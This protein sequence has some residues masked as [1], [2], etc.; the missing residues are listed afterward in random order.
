MRLPCLRRF[1]QEDRGGEDPVRRAL[2]AGIG[3]VLLGD[4]GIGPCVVRLLEAAYT[5]SGEVEI[6]DLGTPSLDLTQRIAGL[7]S[8]IVIDCV[9]SDAAPGTVVFYRKADIVC[10]KLPDRLDPHSPA[11]AECLM[12]AEM[13]G[14]SPQN[15]LLI[16]IVGE[17]CEPGCGLSPAVWRS[18]A[19]AMDAVLLELDRL[20]FD[21]T[22][23][24][25][26][27]EPAIWWSD[28]FHVPV[29]ETAIR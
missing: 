12:A 20:N 4:D 14:A 2:I 27:D 7:D 6:A 15:V 22:K 18:L 23:K 25:L 13:L 26:A 29:L 28:E 11:L 8:L 10:E 19:Q 16:G 3:N 21:Y 9:K 1:G 24:P 5:F 17:P